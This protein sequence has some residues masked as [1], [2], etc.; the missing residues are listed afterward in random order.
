MKCTVNTITTSEADADGNIT[1]NT[2]VDF[3]YPDGGVVKSVDVAH[4][5]PANGNEIAQNLL[6]RAVSEYVKL[7]VPDWWNN[8]KEGQTIEI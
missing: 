2:N 4:F 6:K 5:N 1:V 3:N 7:Q 8:V